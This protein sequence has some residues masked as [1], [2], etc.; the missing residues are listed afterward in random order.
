M[1]Y[2]NPST[3]LPLYTWSPIP[4][5]V[6]QGTNASPPS[7]ITSGSTVTLVSGT[8]Y[9]GTINI[10]G[11][12]NVTI[13]SNGPVSIS[14]GAAIGINAAS[15]TGCI[16]DGVNGITI[17]NC[18]AGSGIAANNSTNI[19]IKQVAVLNTTGTDV[20]PIRFSQSNGTLVSK[21][22]VDGCDDM[23]ICAITTN[24]NCNIL[25]NT[26]LNSNSGTAFRGRAI[27]S[28]A[29]NNNIYN[30]NS[31]TN[32]TFHGIAILQNTNSEISYNTL[33]NCNSNGDSDGGAIYLQNITTGSPQQMVIY[34][35][36]VLSDLVGKGIYLD[37]LCN[38]IRID[39]NTIDDCDIGINLHRAK[40]NIIINNV[41]TR[42]RS[43]CVA[44]ASSAVGDIV[45]NSI[46]YN[47][48]SMLN[49]RTPV[50]NSPPSPQVYNLQATSDVATFATY[51]NNIYYYTEGGAGHFARVWPGGAA[52]D[53]TFAQ[54]KTWSGQDSASLLNPRTW[55]VA[56]TGN[57]TNAGT[58]GSPFLTITK[59]CSVALAGDT[60]TVADGNYQGSIY[61]S[62]SYP[63][64]ASGSPI[65]LKSTNKWGAKI[66]PLTA[67]GAGSG[68]AA[69]FEIRRDWWVFDG[70]E[71]D[72]S[73]GYTGSGTTWTIGGTEW[74]IGL[75]MS[76]QNC[77]AQNC[78][79]HDLRRSQTSIGSGGGG[80]VSDYFY[81]G[82]NNTVQYNVVH[83]IGSGT[84]NTTVHGIYI[85][86]KSIVKGNI[87]YQNAADNI[88][89]WHAA[90]ECEI[91]N[92]TCFKAINGA[93]ILF[94]AGSAGAIAG[95]PRNYRVFNNI[96]YD[97]KNG[98]EVA[99][100]PGTGNLI[101]N[102]LVFGNTTNY[103]LQGLTASNQ[104]SA[105]PA[106]V[107][108]VS[109]GGGDYHLTV[110]SPAKDVGL[111]SLGSSPTS[112]APPIDIDLVSRP[113]NGTYDLGSYEFVQ[114]GGSVSN[115]INGASSTSARG[116][117]VA[118]RSISL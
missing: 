101:S 39:N 28:D 108:Y 48:M 102:N 81:G 90:D 14:P 10:S 84:S 118:N 37:D 114:S 113:Q 91:V 34:Q 5:N 20:M 12:S 29:G 45:G 76:G 88:S 104:V 87:C 75:Y 55:Y 98:I 92:N 61:L 17:R 26:V 86:T 74:W 65:I 82:I 83:H 111:S 110:S 46:T 67:T 56:T 94:G 69:A 59:G 106:F 78:L 79:V 16:I 36:T 70:F 38:T 40:N 18:S 109:T 22:Y 58:A 9:T 99:S 8:N 64:G 7:G 30:A 49:A 72:G 85:E 31:I 73:G 23:A 96:L 112:T 44:L 47:N 27:Y 19:Q 52:S 116:N 80:I 60:V 107:N 115:A 2:P 66:K 71:I 63:N 1:A 32:C 68:N 89:N 35:N 33:L 25:Q 95:A 50:P 11:L 13:T 57:D 54:W 4:T 42:A 43:Q 62:S 97:N 15:T 21:C 105:N 51:N 6:A 53:Y 77:I 117:T 24:S 41:I 100:S 93:G 3:F 103:I